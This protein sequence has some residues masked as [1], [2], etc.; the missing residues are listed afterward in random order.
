MG[1]IGTSSTSLHVNG[2][3]TFIG[4]VT[5]S[6]LFVGGALTTRSSYEINNISSGIIRASSVGIGTTNP[7]QTLQVGATNV[8]GV[9]ING[10]I[11][12]VNSIGSVG[13]GTTAPRSH[14]DI[15]GHTRLKTYSENVENLSIVSNVVIVDLSK[16]QSFICTATSNI[17]EFTILNPPFGSTEF[18]IKISQD[19][20][21]NRTV[22]INS[23]RNSSGNIIPVYWPG[24]GVLPI[25]TPTAD[26]S[27]IYSFK[28]FDGTNIVNTG[29]YGV[30]VGQNFSN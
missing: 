7:L 20:I 24:G 1:T 29:F 22:G 5:T 2:T 28:T 10:H 25:I 8:S 21:G 17:T 4:F 13:I 14:L 11:F 12:V 16:S 9:P 15:E 19:S 27:D 30:V 26:R 6:N 23:F 3:S 18:T